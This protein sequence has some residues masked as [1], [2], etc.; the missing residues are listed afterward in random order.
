LLLSGVLGAAFLGSLPLGGTH[1]PASRLDDALV[2]PLC[3]LVDQGQYE[4]AEA[5]ALELLPGI[6][7]DWGKNSLETAEILDVLTE[8]LWRGGKAA[9]A[10]TLEYAD[11]AL[12]IRQRRLGLDH[13]VVADSLVEKAN[14][15]KKRTQ[16]DE[17]EKLLKRA[18]VLYER[19]YG[20]ADPHVA[21]VL[22][23]L[24]S[25]Y[26]DVGDYAG[27]Q[28]SLLEAIELHEKRCGQDCFDLTG[29]LGNLAK[30]VAALGDYEWAEKLLRRELAI[31]EQA[32]GPQH[33]AGIATIHSLGLNL[34]QQGR[35]M[36]SRVLMKRAISAREDLLGP[37]HPSLAGSVGNLASLEAELGHV[38]EADHNYRRCISILEE[39]VGSDHPDTAQALVNYG[40][41]L[42]TRDYV[43]ART[44]Y[45][46]G[47]KIFKTVHG[48]NH[49]LVAWAHTSLGRALSGIGE[50]EGAES[51]L[52]QAIDFWDGHPSP[53]I[54]LRIGAVREM[55]HLERE[56]GHLAMAREYFEKALSL[57]IE[58]HG[59]DH[60]HAAET[61]TLI[62]EV[63][64]REGAYEEAE[65][66]FRRALE[67]EERTLGTASPSFATALISMG[68]LRFATGEWKGALG[69]YRRALS[70][71]EI[72]YAGPT[73][74]MAEVRLKIARCLSK[75]GS[76]RP[77]TVA[78]LQAEDVSRAHLRL[79]LTGMP[80]SEGLRFAG[81]RSRGL[82]LAFSLVVTGADADLVE[83]AVDSLIQSRALVLDEI[84]RRWRGLRLQQDPA[85]ESLADDLA[86]ARR[87]LAYLVVRGPGDRQKLSEYTELLQGARAERERAE[88]ALAIE[89]RSY[90]LQE[91]R[92]QTRLQEVVAALPK[93]SGLVGFVR[94]RLLDLEKGIGGDELLAEGEP[95]YVAFVLAGQKSGPEVVLLGRAEEIDDLVERIQGH[96]LD[97]T[98]SLGVGE[99][100]SEAVYR[101]DTSL[102]KRRVWEPIADRL[103]GLE[104]V[105]IVPDGALHMINFAALPVGDS[106]Y[107]ID[108]GPQIHYL[109][110]ERDL[111]SKGSG[112]L[113]KGLLALGNPD[114]ENQSLAVA[115]SADSSTPR[116][117]GITTRGRPPTRWIFVVA[118]RASRFSRARRV[119]N[120]SFIWRPTA[121]SSVNTARSYLAPRKSNTVT[122]RV[123]PACLSI[124]Y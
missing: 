43:A 98:E 34:H 48:D 83:A 63:L 30:A 24:G 101:R 28:E 19:A 33:P 50:W 26:Y 92:R 120:E 27:A 17:A 106:D 37:L 81:S 89:S 97:E 100:W 90:R 14:V 7:A 64:L 42:E 67:I 80:E 2:L 105:F 94:I 55:G 68:D 22:H 12:E 124:L 41:F 47:L 1:E 45:E 58:S 72:I 59:P 102:L 25:L 84:A 57:E 39:T 112:S 69:Y 78:A 61:E 40:A 111:V 70:L 8:A 117:S 16:T 114:F 23:N 71:L 74:E 86:A 18:L 66:I 104:R 9:D 85:V 96:I 49:P 91:D 31:Y 56:K 20:K 122:R 65:S 107:L 79:M 15:L 38:E 11:R 62:G 32:V 103:G 29:T 51:H 116:T 54:A 77:A 115:V 119:V 99:E 123:D 82:D 5:A 121:S 73:L 53:N 88:R 60:A 3:A 21:M 44:H 93:K 118:G 4:E 113:G 46:K 87:R 110:A 10:A 13:P 6:E 75:L 108:E 109:S 35:Y 76:G 52:R 95:Y 36:E